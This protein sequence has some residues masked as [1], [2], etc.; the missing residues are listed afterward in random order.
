M[1]ISLLVNESDANI[2]KAEICTKQILFFLGTSFW[3]DA[4]CVVSTQPLLHVQISYGKSYRAS[5]IAYQKTADSSSWSNEQQLHDDEHRQEDDEREAQ[6]IAK[7][8]RHLHTTL[9]SDALH[10]EVRAIADV[11]H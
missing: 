2:A 11:G 8:R 7:E 4:R 1:I 10:H 3:H 5:S 9:L 6:H